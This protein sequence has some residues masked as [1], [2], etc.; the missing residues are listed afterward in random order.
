MPEFRNKQVGGKLMEKLLEVAENNGI[1]RFLVNT[2]TNDMDQIMKF[3]RR[4]GFEP[5][6]VELF[7]IDSD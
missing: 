3:Y 2:V 7:E 6:F 4:F 5:W 1:K